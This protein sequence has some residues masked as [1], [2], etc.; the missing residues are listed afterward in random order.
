MAVTFD[1]PTGPL[2]SEGCVK[3]H[4]EPGGPWYE[5]KIRGTATDPPNHEKG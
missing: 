2:I 4:I 3:I 5:L 1:P